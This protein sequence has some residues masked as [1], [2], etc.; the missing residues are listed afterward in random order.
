MH[1][2][3]CAV[4]EKMKLLNTRK[5]PIRVQYVICIALVL[6]VSGI[7]FSIKSYIGYR[8]VALLLLMTVSFIAMLFEIVPVIIAA[9]LSALIWNFFFIPPL[10]TFHI[11]QTEDALLFFLYFLIAFINTILTFKIRDAEKKAR[12]K[13]E[14]DNIIRLYNTLFHSLSHELRT[15]ISTIIG[16]LDTLKENKATLS[17]ENHTALLS[18]IDNASFRLNREVDNLLN[19]SRLESGLLKLNIDWCDIG[20]VIHSVIQKLIPNS[21][22]SI[23][24]NPRKNL[25]FFRLDAG[26]IELVVYNLIHNA[27]HHTPENTTILIDAFHHSDL[28]VITVSDNGQGFPE[29]E[30]P[31]VFTKFYRLPSNKTGGSGLGLSIVKGFAEAHNGKVK[32]E[33]LKTGGAKFTIEIPAE[34][35]Y[36]NNL[37]NE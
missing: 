14:K 7:S 4:V 22:V 24:F 23:E 29:N 37:K 35:T 11:E 17:E 12:D 18:V 1:N 2:F 28:C 13:E 3:V 10:F 31:M 15:P 6:F 33:N 8:V 32:L 20:E 34:A 26:I 25:P 21:K 16:A 9:V 30:I 27:I 36:I 5:Y 19:M